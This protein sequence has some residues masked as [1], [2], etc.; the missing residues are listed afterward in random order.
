MLPLFHVANSL[1]LLQSI[2][3]ILFHT[4]SDFSEI[5]NHKSSSKLN[6]VFDYRFVRTNRGL[7]YTNLKQQPSVTKVFGY[8][9]GSFKSNQLFHCS[10]FITPILRQSV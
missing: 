7:L 2:F 1:G 10:R 5:T 3:N 6:L 4:I 9:V 8:K